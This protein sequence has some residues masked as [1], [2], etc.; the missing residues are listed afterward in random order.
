[1]KKIFFLLFTTL[2][3]VLFGQ[4]NPDNQ[5]EILDPTGTDKLYSQSRGAVKSIRLDTLKFQ[6]YGAYY[7]DTALNYNPTTSPDS[8]PD[9][10]RVSFVKGLDGNVYYIDRDK[11]AFVMGS[12]GGSGEINTASNQGAAGVGLYDT[13]AGVDLQFRNINAGSSKITV[14]HDSGNKE[15]DIDVDQTALSI[16]ESQISDLQ[17]YLTTEVDGDIS[18]EGSLT[19]GAG[20]TT[21]SVISS[22]TSGSTDV[23]LTAGSGMTISEVGN[24]ITL[25]STGGHDAV[26]LA[27]T[28]TYLSLTGQEITVDQITESD[29]SDLQAYLTAEVDGS[30]SNE[31]SLTVGAGTGTTSIISSNTS[32]STD[33][34]LTAGTG[35][36]IGEVGNTITLFNSQDDVTLAGTGTYLSLTGQEITVDQITESDISDLQAYLTAEVDGSISNEGALTVGAGTGSTSLI[37]SNTSGSTDVTLTAGTGLTIG[38]VGNVITLTNDQDAVTLAGT[39]T[40]LSLT[41]QEI[42]VDPITESD[43][44]DLDH[45]DTAAI[46]DNVT[47]EIAALTEKVT[48]ASGDLI[49]I[50]DSAAGNAKKYIQVGNLP[51]G[52]GGESNTG[53][54]QGV[55]GVG[56]YDTKVGIDLQFRNIN[57]GSSKIT[58]T[59]D[60][61]NKEIDIDV[62]DTA[63]SIT[64]SQISDL[65]SY[66][67]AEVDGSIS[68]EGALTVGAGTTTTSLISSN[69]SGST[70]VTL[71]EGSGIE[72]TEAGNTITIASTGG[73]DAVTLAGTGTYLSLT[74]QEITVDPITESDISDLQAY[75][76]AEVD[77]SISNEG[78]L[79]V[80]AGTGSTSLISSNTSGSTDVTLTAGTGL[81]ISEVGNVITLANDQAA[82]TLAGTGTYLSLTGQEITVDPITES[83]ISDL[84]AYLTAEV[85]GSISNEG[86]LTVGAG[87]GSTSLISSNTSGST[88]VTLTAGTG[89]TISEVGNVITLAND[90]AAVTLAGTGTYLSL[91][92][93]EITVDPITESD[94][95]DLQAYLT[96]EVDG[97]ITNEGALTVGAGTSTTSIISSNTSGS[98]DV[99]ITA[100]TGLTIAEAGN[101]ITIANDQSEVTLAGAYDYLTISGQEITRNQIDLTT[102]VTGLLPGSNIN[103]IT[104]TQIS[105]LQSYLTAEVDGSI[106]NEGSLTVGAGTGSTSLIS[107]NTSGSTDVTL[108]A[109]TGLTISEVGNV[110]TLANDQAAVTL[111]GTGTYLSLTGQEITVDEI[112]ESDI[113]DLQSYL[114]AEVD[115]S[116]SNEGSLTVGAGTG[117]TS[118]ISSN[119]SGSTDVTLT[120]GTGLT[121]GEV[122]NVITLANDQDAVTLAGTGTYLSL[123]GQEITVD[124]ITESDISD[125]QSYLTAEV[126]GS[127]SNEGSLTVG[128]GTSTTSLISSNTSGSTD[129]TLTA[130]TGL[131]ISEVG[132]VITLAASG[133]TDTF[134]EIQED[135]VAISTNAP[136]LDFASADFTITETPTDDFDITTV[137]T[138][139]WTGT[140][141][142]LEGTAYLARANHTGTQLK[143]TISDFAHASTH[144]TSGGDEIDGD[145][146]DIDWTPTNYTPSTTPTEADNVDNL[147]AHLYG[148]DQAIYPTF[149][150][151]KTSD[152]SVAS[153]TTL[154]DDND[155]VVALEAN[156]Y[157]HFEVMH[158]YT[159]HS[160][161]DL[162]VGFT[163]PAGS[164]GHFSVRYS[165]AGAGNAV[166]GAGA[167]QSAVGSSTVS[168]SGSIGYIYTAG[169]AGNLQLVWAQN[170]SNAT[171]TVMKE[172]SWIRVVK[173]Q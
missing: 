161:A 99:T 50:E 154:Q 168:V 16:T 67:T 84:Q 94:I 55:G 47:G 21:T 53:S 27:G 6:Y 70:D 56:V 73:H 4:V 18:N 171:A 66:L 72:L 76:T 122:G 145:K 158:V 80:G 5:P 82:V 8:I 85:D 142:G 24:V 11:K 65:Q 108:T 90:Q 35:L 37:S 165:A 33:V 110:I 167:L 30:I 109:G 102:D 15:V 78:S 147:T 57:A 58:V 28:G 52:G 150:E 106:S 86:S 51:T 20:T 113:S 159:G 54:N 130:G 26:T 140:F 139:A 127:I 149:Y 59:H 60:S 44:S 38:E 14:T 93:Q 23:T 45:D 101:V 77:G 162:K 124:E 36:L 134:A 68:N 1:M 155:L 148:I 125:L 92:G 46:H 29:I 144:I 61:G 133:G 107:S 129:V 118:L 10:I 136:T 135:G 156:S 17:S 40:Y 19:V 105:D 137:K 12:G 116:I 89:L 95:S 120:A 87:T 3:V 157:Y 42:T 126:D 152:E 100:G 43:I 31:G 81:T 75:L 160:A 163:G 114:T 64:E 22:N 123:T 25:A 172:G 138:G 112:T 62:D 132:N 121:I 151:V 39:G 97:S 88:D 34:T 170:T 131:T 7:D 115:G 128:A 103:T 74:G 2:N 98:T 111:A 143:S 96:A 41:G 146:L 69:T 71:E 48:P 164:T 104:E 49:L 91:T 166:G 79:T 13:K 173:I 119:T 32:G 153:S 169:T 83:D 9:S 117:S 141:D 63:L